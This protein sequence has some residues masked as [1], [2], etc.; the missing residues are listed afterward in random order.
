MRE[1][2]E[3]FIERWV[4]FMKDNPSE[5]KKHHTEFIDS[6]FEKAN[7]VIQELSKTK[8]GKAKIIKMYN[9]KNIKGY[10]NL[11]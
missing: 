9:I 10:K 3:D 4:K 7:K 2:H 11:L 5:W 1:L 8:E 6:Q